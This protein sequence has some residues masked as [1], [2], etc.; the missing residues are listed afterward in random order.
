MSVLPFVCN[1]YLTQSYHMKVASGQF[2]E[3]LLKMSIEGHSSSL[4]AHFSDLVELSESLTR[5]GTDSH[6]KIGTVLYVLLFREFTDVT[7]Q[8][9]IIHALQTHI[10]SSVKW[11]TDASLDALIDLASRPESQR[12]LMTRQAIGLGSIT[13]TLRGAGNV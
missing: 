13:D 12:M 3:A 8:H 6:Q 11:E 4:K 1:S 10:G 9:E 7:Y 5:A 2:T